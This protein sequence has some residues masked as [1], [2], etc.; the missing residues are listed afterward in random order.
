M[1]LLL[2]SWKQCYLS[3]KTV[4]FPSPFLPVSYRPCAR[5]VRLLSSLLVSLI[6][7]AAAA[8]YAW[9]TGEG[10]RY[11]ELPT[12]GSG[13]TG[14]TLMPVAVTGV[15]FTNQLSDKGAAE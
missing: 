8:P 4:R 9:R 5:I 2:M 3:S 12:P 15:I 11:A 13:K 14:F 10:C 7:S 6:F 1:N